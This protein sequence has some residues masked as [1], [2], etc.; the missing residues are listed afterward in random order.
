[1]A[2]RRIKGRIA[3]STASYKLRKRQRKDGRAGKQLEQKKVKLEKKAEAILKIAGAEYDLLGSVGKTKS[4]LVPGHPG[5]EDFLYFITMRKHAKELQQLYPNP[6]IG[7]AEAVK[8]LGG[9]QGIEENVR[10]INEWLAESGRPELKV[11]GKE[12]ID[13]IFI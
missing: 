7:R 1:M 6:K 9:E 13:L 3:E 11:S 12:M 5:R 4:L 8:L 10:R 2:K